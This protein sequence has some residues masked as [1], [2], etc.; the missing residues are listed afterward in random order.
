MVTAYEE[1]AQACHDQHLW[2]ELHTARA[3]QGEKGHE[4]RKLER[5]DIVA[6]SGQ[7]IVTALAIRGLEH[8]AAE[9]LRQLVAPR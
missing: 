3:L 2:L 7:I 1:L 4:Y 9:A 5:I 6:R 8:A